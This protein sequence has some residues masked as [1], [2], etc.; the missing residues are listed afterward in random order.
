MEKNLKNNIRTYVCIWIFTC[1]NIDEYIYICVYIHMYIIHY[2]FLDICIY[3]AVTHHI[4]IYIV[5]VCYMHVCMLSCFGCVQLF[6]TLW[7]IA[8]QA[9]LPMGFSRQEYW[10]EWQWVA[11][12]SPGDLPNPGINP[13]SPVVPAL[14]VDSLLPSHLGKPCMLRR[15]PKELFGQPNHIYESFWCIIEIKTALWINYISIK[16]L[17]KK[18]VEP[19]NSCYSK[20]SRGFWSKTVTL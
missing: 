6:V 1:I 3:W 2:Y 15:N 10:S 19:N 18:R 13:V 9:S 20:S 8:Q 5:Y 12:P 16:N 11:L 4:Y 17:K 14:Q 7:T